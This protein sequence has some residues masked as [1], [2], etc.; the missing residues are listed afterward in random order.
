MIAPA[1]LPIVNVPTSVMSPR[2]TGVA[3]VLRLVVAFGA[4]SG[5]KMFRATVVATWFSADMGAV[6]NPNPYCGIGCCMTTGLGCGA[7][8]RRSFVV[9]VATSVSADGSVSHSYAWNAAKAARIRL[10]KS[11]MVL[12]SVLLHDLGR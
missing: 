8:V 2:L 6:L 5:S 10:V 11:R 9:V 4:R 1:T 7:D 12:I 3:A